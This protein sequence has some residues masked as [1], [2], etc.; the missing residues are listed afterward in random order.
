VAPEMHRAGAAAM[1][2]QRVQIIT[3]IHMEADNSFRG[4]ADNIINSI[5]GA[6]TTSFE[7][8]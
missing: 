4:C 3:Q 7:V 1:L 2:V 5:L 8:C 6:F